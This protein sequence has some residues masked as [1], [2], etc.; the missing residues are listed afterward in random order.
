MNNNILFEVPAAGCV[1]AG[2][3]SRR[4]GADKAL[5]ELDGKPLIAI[6][7]ERFSGFPEI[8]VSA[9]SA[10]SYASFGAR[11]VADEDPGLGPLGGLI[12]A[13]KAAR[14]E[15]VCFR[16]VDAPFVPAELHAMLAKACLG[17]DAAVPV[18]KGSIEPLLACLAK[19]ALPALEGLAA[20]KNYK[21]ADVF[22]LLDTSYIDL[23][24]P[25]TVLEL[26][27]PSAYLVNA[28]DPLTFAKIGD[29]R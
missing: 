25:E 4:M 20:A 26:G 11:V 27:E 13:L 6:A 8:L 22:P 16:P 7:L 15:Y 10:E 5:L 23:D 28:N 1:L 18:C 12:S 3:R 24:D 9:A 14:S 19:S 21:A 17:R 2:G 29:R